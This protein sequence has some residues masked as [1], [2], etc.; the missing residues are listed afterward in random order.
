MSIPSFQAFQEGAKFIKETNEKEAI[1]PLPYDP[2]DLD[3]IEEK[4]AFEPD[5]AGDYWFE[6]KNA[7]ERT[8]NA[9]NVYTAL[10]L[11]V[12]TGKRNAL[13]WDNMSYTEN[14]HWRLKQFKDCTGTAPT[15]HDDYIGLT[16]Q[17]SFKQEEYKG[18]TK[19]KVDSF[20]PAGA[21]NE[22]KAAFAKSK[23]TE[24][25]F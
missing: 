7:E 15:E 10:T 14:M 8:S 19:L 6:V 13:V 24:E 16:G 23:T 12:D 20:I 22:V 4:P 3:N 5:A 11:E 2:A 1:M 17:A 9:G 25:E 21:A 18:K